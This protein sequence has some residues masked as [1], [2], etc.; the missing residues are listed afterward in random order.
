MVPVWNTYFKKIIERLE[1]AQ[2]RVTRLELELTTDEYEKI[3]KKLRL[4][5]LETIRKRRGLIQ[6]IRF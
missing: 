6:F 5:T 1:D 2:H 4:R 3:L